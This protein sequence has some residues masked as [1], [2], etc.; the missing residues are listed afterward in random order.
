MCDADLR[1]HLTN[2]GPKFVELGDERLRM[3][4]DWEAIKS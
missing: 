2:T 1:I 3:R 4:R